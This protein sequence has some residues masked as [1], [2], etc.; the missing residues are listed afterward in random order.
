MYRI[1]RTRTIYFIFT[2]ICSEI[3]RIRWRICNYSRCWKRS[4]HSWR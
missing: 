2:F 3:R 1:K 4:P